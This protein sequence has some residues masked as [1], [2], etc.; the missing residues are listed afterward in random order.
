[1]F[2]GQLAPSSYWRI[3]IVIITVIR[4]LFSLRDFLWPI[5]HCEEVT[6]TLNYFVLLAVMERTKSGKG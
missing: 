6:V 5:R 2:S 3:I 4:M 1:M